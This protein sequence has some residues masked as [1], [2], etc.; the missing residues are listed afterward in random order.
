[1]LPTSLDVDRITARLMNSWLAYKAN[2]AYVFPDLI[3]D[4]NHFPWPPEKIISNPP[5]TPL[6]AL[7]SGPTAG[8]SWGPTDTAP[9]AISHVWYD[10]VCPESKR[11]IIATP[12]VKPAV[13]NAEGTEVFAAWEK[14]LK[15]ATESCIEVHHIVEGD[16]YYF[17]QTFDMHL[18]TSTRIL[19]LWEGYKNSPVSRLLRASPIVQSAVDRNEYLFV[20]R[21]PRPT[22]PAPVNPFERTMALHLRRGDYSSHCNYLASGNESFF[23]WNQLEFLPDHFKFPPAGTTEEDRMTIYAKHC[24]PEHEDIVEKARR[25]RDEYIRAAKKGEYRYLDMLYLATNDHSE[26][27]DKLKLMMRQSGWRTILTTQDLELDV[28]QREVGMA[29]DMELL[30]KAAVFVGNGVC[31]FLHNNLALSHILTTV[32]VIYQ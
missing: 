12:D 30:R 28:E 29:V 9:R 11:R 20:P 18:W 2:R 16:N 10:T 4:A 6:N 14:V 19:S 31:V 7:I 8:G 25:A 15:D 3:W 26:W 5:R 1:M 21:G 27:L 32:V 23:G 24:Y 17:G 13:A 22:V